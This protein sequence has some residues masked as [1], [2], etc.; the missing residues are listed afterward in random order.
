MTET[1]ISV[2]L[3]NKPVLILLCL[4]QKLDRENTYEAFSFLGCWRSSSAWYLFLGGRQRD[5]GYI[6]FLIYSPVST[7]TV[8]ASHLSMSI[9]QFLI[10]SL[11]SQLFSLLMLIVCFISSLNFWLLDDEGYV[12]YL[13]F[14]SK[15]LHFH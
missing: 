1:Q 10:L 2:K 8:Q 5:I 7:I 3:I 12:M 6:F 14:I 9:L 15:V 13:V 11:F 4:N